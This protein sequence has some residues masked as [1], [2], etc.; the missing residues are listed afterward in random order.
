[1]P[2]VQTN[3]NDSKNIDF[4]I[5]FFQNYSEINSNIIFLSNK[6]NRKIFDK[7]FFV[8]IENFWRNIN[9]VTNVTHSLKVYYAYLIQFIFFKYN[10]DNKSE[11]NKS[12][13]NNIISSIAKNLKN[14]K[15]S[16]ILLLIQSINEY[17]SKQNYKV[18]N[19]LQSTINEYFAQLITKADIS[20]DDIKIWLDILILIFKYNF[21]NVN[22]EIFG[23]IYENYIKRVDAKS[24]SSQVFTD[25]LVADFMLDT[26][27]FGAE[28]KTKNN[29]SLIDPSCGCG[30]FLTASAKKVFENNFNNN[31]YFCG[32]D[33]DD[34]PLYLADTTLN[35][36]L[37][38]KNNIKFNLFKTV[39]SI[40]EFIENL[41][42]LPEKF[43]YVVGNPPYIGYKECCNQKVLFTQLIHQKKILMSNIYGVNLN[44]VPGRT[45]P[46]APMPNLYAFFMAL[47]IALLKDGGKLSYI[48]PQTVLT[49][50][51]LDVIRY[52]I[53]KYTTILKIININ[54][55]M[56][57]SR[58]L[59][60]ESKVATSSL[61]FVIQR[62]QPTEN[63]EVE[64]I[65]CINS[66]DSIELSIENIKNG[67]NIDRKNI[68]QS[69]LLTNISNWSYIRFDET[70]TEIINH[71]NKCESY[72][73][74]R[75][76]EI[77]MPRFNALF[78]IDGGLMYPKE[79][80][81]SLK[82]QMVNDE[83]FNLT[84]TKPDGFELEIT[85]QIIEKKDIKLQKGAQGFKVF[86]QKYKVVWSYLNPKRFYF[87]DQNIM[88]K[89]A[90]PLISSN[91][92]C[93][94]LFLFSILNAPINWFVFKK[95]FQSENEKNFQI[96][97]RSLKEFGRI[98]LINENNYLIKQEIINS[99]ELFL[100][101]KVEGTDNQHNKLIQE[102]INDLVFC[103]YFNIK[104]ENIGFNYAEN[105]R[106]ICKENKYYSKIENY[107]K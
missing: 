50:T 10:I 81:E 15:L 79:C 91:S 38:N 77:S 63:H 7:D 2:V 106:T 85:D 71:Y 37:N 26:M 62:T 31:Y 98:P 9:E 56:F 87:S 30:A 52:H 16:E 4:Y 53:S 6:K 41:R 17:A 23:S 83:Y 107:L 96:G 47:G 12:E 34:F 13:I 95:L 59:K 69:E 51:D 18:Y 70:A 80:I 97:I 75:M 44:T 84:N 40:S 14:N 86:E 5:D 49:A 76:P 88:V 43:D 42:N 93:E 28:Q 54:A 94:I 55:N 46:Y 60:Q 3:K 65:N 48:I 45:K 89:F 24:S 11:K 102:Y 78:Y 82:Y 105:I 57:I 92:R 101:K 104:I 72:D 20:F 100:E 32:L 90:W 29:I 33:I 58:G 64:I 74:Y 22:D 73:I 19:D 68:L 27:D 61:I 25:S 39:D 99:T 36:M 35:L 103:L 1:M 21:T 8:L 67:N 66:Q